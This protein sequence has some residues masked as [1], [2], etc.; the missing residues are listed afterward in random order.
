VVGNGVAY[1]AWFRVVERLPAGAA[2][3]GALITPCVAVA[4]SVWLAG[5]TLHPRDLT[6]IAMIGS[7][8]ALVL[9]EQLGLRRR[10]PAFAGSE[11][12]SGH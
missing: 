1:F 6:A 2:G 8:L 11:R 7:A 3:V 4:S 12:G 9:V 5:E 10:F